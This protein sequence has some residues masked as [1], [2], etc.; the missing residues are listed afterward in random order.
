MK[1]DRLSFSFL[2]QSFQVFI[3]ANAFAVCSACFAFHTLF[4]CV[5]PKSAETRLVNAAQ[6]TVGHPVAKSKHA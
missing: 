3:L 4:P 6:A 5:Q 2:L 1:T